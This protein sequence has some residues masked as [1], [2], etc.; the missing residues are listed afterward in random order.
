[1]KKEELNKTKESQ[2]LYETSKRR[3]YETVKEKKIETLTLYKK[4]IVAKAAIKVNY[5][6]K[7][8]FIFNRNIRDL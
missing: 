3:E 2:K 1:M 6:V 7:K 8:C 5:E 4:E